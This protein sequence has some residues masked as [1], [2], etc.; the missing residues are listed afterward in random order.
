MQTKIL[1]AIIATAVVAVALIGVTFALVSA[2]PQNSTIYSQA[3]AAPY[4]GNYGYMMPYYNNGT[5]TY[6]YPQGTPHTSKEHIHMALA[7]AEACVDATGK[8][9]SP[10]QLSQPLFFSFLFCWRW[11]IA[12]EY[13]FFD[14][15]F[16]WFPS[17]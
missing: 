2:Q 11:F 3:P 10:P 16:S 4:S 6:P 8:P 5:A 1:L 7:W 9:S 15:G 14:F 13:A 12:G 17:S